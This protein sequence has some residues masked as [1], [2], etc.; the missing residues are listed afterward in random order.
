ML[1]SLESV[2]WL[3]ILL[4][5]LPHGALDPLFA[6]QMNWLANLRRQL[7][8][9]AGYLAL[10]AG[11]AISWYFMPLLMLIG[12][13]VYSAWHFGGDYAQGLLRLSYGGLILSAPLVCAPVES[14]LL[15]QAVSLG[16]STTMLVRV[17]P[18]IAALC[19]VTLVLTYRISKLRQWAELALLWCSAVVFDPLFY[20]A[21]YFCCAHSLRHYLHAFT[22]LNAYSTMH[23]MLT[24]VGFSAIAWLVGGGIYYGWLQPHGIEFSA[25]VFIG[26]AALTVPHMIVM[27]WYQHWQRGQHALTA[28]MVRNGNFQ[29]GRLQ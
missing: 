11:V 5:G 1:W 28:T 18:A 2:A 21:L 15:L 19:A 17:S 14:G 26:L 3:T 6:G 20:F 16:E 29:R 10:A 13:L 7:L 9:F 8:F 4:I 12:F 24:L 23:V 22:D 27:E 25:L